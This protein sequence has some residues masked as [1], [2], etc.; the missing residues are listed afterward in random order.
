MQFVS[1]VQLV[2]Y[3]DYN[4]GVY[5]IGL[6]QYVSIVEVCYSDRDAGHVYTM[7]Q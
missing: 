6:V 4:V 3:S 1:I 2:Y 7:L 5:H